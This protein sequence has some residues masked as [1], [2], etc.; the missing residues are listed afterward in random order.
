MMYRATIGT[1]QSNFI[2]SSK[3]SFRRQ[4]IDRKAIQIG[5]LLT[6]TL[7]F[8]AAKIASWILPWSFLL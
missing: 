2:F 7:H 3:V 8:K 4:K 1:M 6:A 5:R